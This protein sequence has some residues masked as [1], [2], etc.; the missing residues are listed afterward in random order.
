MLNRNEFKLSIYI[1]IFFIVSGIIIFQ[2]LKPFFFDHSQI[3]TFSIQITSYKNGYTQSDFMKELEKL[4]STAYATYESD[5]FFPFITTHLQRETI[6]ML[7]VFRKNTDTEISEIS[8]KPNNQFHFQLPFHSQ[9]HFYPIA[10]ISL[11]FPSIFGS[12]TFDCKSK[13]PQ[14]TSLIETENYTAQIIF[15]R[16]KCSIHSY[17]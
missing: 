17:S 5:Y 8:S 10:Y 15:N 14:K 2:M 9:K 7:P 13:H 16:K 12:I 3:L 4:N 11:N 6:L 1:S